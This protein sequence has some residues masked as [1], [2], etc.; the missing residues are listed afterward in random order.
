VALGANYLTKYR[1]SIAY[2]VFSGGFANTQT[3]RDFYALSV[4]MDF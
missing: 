1:A 2:T 3:D 4:S